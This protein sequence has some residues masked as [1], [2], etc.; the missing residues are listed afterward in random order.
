M[1][2]P[3][4]TTKSHFPLLGIGFVT[5]VTA[6]IKAISQRDVPIIDLDWA[7]SQLLH[8]PGEMIDFARF[9]VTEVPQADVREALED[10]RRRNRTDIGFEAQY[11]ECTPLQRALLLEVAAGAKLFS[12]ES[13]QRLATFVGQAA[14]VA[15]ASVHN[16]LAQLEAKGIL[17]KRETRGRYD[18]EDEHLRSWVDQVARADGAGPKRA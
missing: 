8:R 9:M 3:H 4:E 7:F 17:A 15:P 11:A 1:P 12:H 10:F 5:F 13:R 18:F 2:V 14:P 6:R 16:T